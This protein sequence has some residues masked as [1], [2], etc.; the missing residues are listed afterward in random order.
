MK[1]REWRE[2]VPPIA[3]AA[4]TQFQ[5]EHDRSPLARF[6]A[7]GATLVAAGSQIARAGR[8]WPGAGHPFADPKRT[9]TGIPSDI[10]RPVSQKSVFAGFLVGAPGLE[11]GTR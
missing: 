5:T 10:A 3:S 11:P 4:R 2:A 7:L 6:P 9:L 1:L 8:F